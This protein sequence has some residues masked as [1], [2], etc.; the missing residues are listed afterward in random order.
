[1]THDR[2]H[3]DLEARRRA[4]QKT[5]INAYF[6]RDDP[7][8]RTEAPD[9]SDP[10]STSSDS[11]P[12]VQE[13]TPG[14]AARTAI[15]LLSSDS[16]SGGSGESGPDAGDSF[17]GS[18]S[19]SHRQ[20]GQEGF[21]NLS[22]D[23]GSESDSENE[24]RP[25]PGKKTKPNYD[26]ARRFQLEWQARL[27]WAE[28]V[29]SDD[30][31]LHMVRC[32]TCTS[33]D[34]REKLLAPKLDTLLK[35]E[36]RRRATENMV[37]KGLKKGEVY[38]LKSCR[39]QQNL[40]ICVARKPTSVLRHVNIFGSLERKKKKVQFA[41]LFHI[42]SQGRPLVHYE[43][44]LQLYQYIDV[45]NLP[46]MHWSDSSGWQMAEFLYAEVRDAIKVQCSDAP[47]FAVT[48]DETTSCDNGSW[49]SIHAYIC[50]DWSRIPLLIGLKRIIEAPNADHLTSV[51]LEALQSGAG[52]GAGDLSSR[53][54]CFGADGVTVFQ[55]ARTGVTVQLAQ[56]YAPFS[57]GVHC[58]AHRVNLAA[59]TLSSTEVFQSTEKLMAKAHAFFNHSPKRLSE[60]QKLA[61][62][63]DTKGLRPLKNVATK[64][65]S[66]LEPLRRILSEYCTLIAKMH[67]DRAD[68]ADA[69][70]SSCRFHLC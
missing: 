4:R 55:G 21:V 6:R 45:P 62:V 43:S 53:L 31:K 30:G 41:S 66:L 67:Q 16:G 7:R 54:L 9:A 65:V 44:L 19:G 52:V 58:M 70:V 59:R 23:E 69:K 46:R 38:V 11:P 47:F 51:V 37:A 17:I 68:S 10:T 5:T 40:A 24:D 60:F 63:I 15:T 8:E 1:L 3:R 28:G 29:L 32:R 49:M 39:H 2:Y 48:C 25:S 42:L 12:S 33:V 13:C 18:S 50:Q 22:D 20:E 57:I 35:H 34:G 64:W 27:P 14:S 56:K 61:D 36:G 26:R